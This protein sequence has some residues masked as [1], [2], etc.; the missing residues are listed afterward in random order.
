[1][2]NIMRAQTYQILHSRNV[3]AVITGFSVL[4]VIFAALVQN[5]AGETPLKASEV[6][7]TLMA[8][9]TTFCTL[10]TVIVTAMICGD[11]F[12][13]RAVNFELTSGA[14]RIDSYMGRAV[15]AMCF[16]SLAAV[17]QYVIMVMTAS[18]LSDSWGC[19]VAFGGLVQRIIISIPVFL[20]ISAF[21]IMLSYIIKK[22]IAVIVASQLI[23]V[24][25]SIISGSGTG[26]KSIE[27]LTG[28]GSLSRVA[29]FEQWYTFA[30][31]GS[32]HIICESYVTAGDTA[33]LV[34]V[35]VIFAAAYLAVGY[36]FFSKD[37]LR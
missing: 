12:T 5:N 26:R 36:G 35:S 33:S 29:S 16:A 9:L 3:R 19:E 17:L 8:I 7:S 23:S 15:L 32:T 37:D 10:L 13:D 34:I 28:V 2:K 6:C 18:L 24:I 11:D 1:M 14:R 4:T 30:L 20:R 22:P 27:L 25:I 21:Y 31:D